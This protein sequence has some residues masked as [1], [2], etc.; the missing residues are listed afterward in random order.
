MNAKPPDLHRFYFSTYHLARDFVVASGTFTL[1][2]TL[3]AIAFKPVQTLVVKCVDAVAAADS[4]VGGLLFVGVYVALAFTLGVLAN[5]AGMLVEALILKL[6]FAKRKWSFEAFYEK[7]KKEISDLNEKFIKNGSDLYVKSPGK[8][9]EPYEP[10][11][12]V[13]Y[14]IGYF[15]LHNPTGYTHV[16]RQYAY[17]SL[18]RQSATYSFCLCLGQLVYSLLRNELSSLGPWIFTI[19][20]FLL[21]LLSAS[22]VVLMKRAVVEIEYEFIVAT[23]NFVRGE[24]VDGGR[25]EEKKREEELPGASNP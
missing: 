23:A 8:E 18:Y 21:F 12:Q 20:F 2:V 3:A 16:Y 13:N 4:W 11:Q 14:L 19:L 9:E 10:R 25:K 15:R 22:G 17:R 7:G 6:D 5:R 24:V 1:F